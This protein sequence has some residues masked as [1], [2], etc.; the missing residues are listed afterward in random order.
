MPEPDSPDL[1]YGSAAWLDEIESFATDTAV[2]AAR[3]TPYTGAELK[4]ALTQIINWSI[5]LYLPVHP[6]DLLTEIRI[7]SFIANGLPGY[8]DA[9]RSNQRAQLRAIRTA[10]DRPRTAE[11][12]SSADPSAPY[13]KSDIRRL[14]SWAA[15]QATEE[16]R[17][18]ARS[19]LSLGIGAGLAAGEIADLR[20]N[21]IRIDAQGVQV[22]VENKRPRTVQIRR[23]WEEPLIDHARFA[24]A[25][26]YFIRPERT[27]SS[28]NFLN[29][30]IEKSLG[31]DFR[32][33]SQRMRATWIV[34]HLTLGTPMGVLMEAAGV[35]SLE[36]FT[37]FMQFVPAVPGRNAR[38]LLRT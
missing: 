4:R 29:G 6:D 1:T 22:V 27:T 30:L 36:A 15:A 34:E 19:V 33:Q 32:P 26:H 37:R 17:R 2:F 9:S 20:G 7:S 12:L 21:A 28:R 3:S 14:Q 24:A 16:L 31:P 8:T 5:D 25:D 38:A 23:E 11:P 35:Q 10:L 18:D 13:V